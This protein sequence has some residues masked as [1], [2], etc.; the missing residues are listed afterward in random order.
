MRA[1]LSYWLFRAGSAIRWYCR[2]RTRYDVHSPHIVEFLNEVY[3]DR[4]YYHAFAKIRGIR[5]SWEK[6]KVTVKLT[7]H[8]A[9]SKTTARGE[10]SAAS[11]V[12][13]NAI[14]DASG[15]F[16]F[17]LALWIKA[18]RL[19]E[20]GTNAG[21]STLYLAEADTRAQVQTVE[22]N[23][24]LA[25]LA[26]R[27]FSLAKLQ[28]T[29]YVSLFERW[30]EENPPNLAAPYDLIFIDGDH[31]Y[32]PTL[33]Y[34]DQLLPATNPAG[35]IVVADIHWSEGMEKAWAEL[36]DRP[37]VTASVD[38]YHFGLLF[39]KPGLEGPHV[40]LIPTRFKP[41]RLGFFS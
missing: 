26:Q 1:P 39:L 19:L 17:R 36:K 16:L 41:W 31:R 9:K 32:Q 40:T 20:F 18:K 21:I 6:E 27:T 23:P 12:A 2:A 14:N 4:R 24:A 8:G 13:T 22:G 3:C 15:R 10:R 25:E 7:S 34:V 5:K 30:L 29:A 37:G 38:T 28:P 35:I 33:D 11:L